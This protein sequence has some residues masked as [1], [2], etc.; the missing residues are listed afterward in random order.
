MPYGRPSRSERT[1]SRCAG[2]VGTAA[3]QIAKTLGA[4]VIAVARR[5]G[6]AQQLAALGADHVVPLV[7]DGPSGFVTSP[8]G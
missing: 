3:I 4:T 2:G 8:T 1:R 6:V 5:Q 7:P